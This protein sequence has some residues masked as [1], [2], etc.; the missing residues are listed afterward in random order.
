MCADEARIEGVKIIEVPSELRPTKE[1]Y[2]EIE[3]RITIRTAETDRLLAQ[4]QVNA[5]FSLPVL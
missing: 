5:Q 1:D 2:R 3:R 4:S